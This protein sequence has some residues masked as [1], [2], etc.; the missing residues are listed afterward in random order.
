MKANRNER[1]LTIVEMA[2]TVTILS[3]LALVIGS[4]LDAG[5]GAY[6][7]TSPSAMAQLSHRSVEKVTERIAF[8]GL[9]TLAIGPEG[10]PDGSVL[11][12]R[13]CQ[14]SD[15]GTQVWGKPATIGWEP[16]PGDPEDGKDNDGDGFVDEGSVVLAINAGETDEHRVVLANGVAR[17]L[18][19]EKPNGLDDNGNGLVDER[20]LSFEIRDRAVHVRMTLVRRGRDGQVVTRTAR[21]TVALR[22]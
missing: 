2:I 13:A 21:D 6:R 17:H 8:A 15:A 11:T 16:E 3:G 5:L 18:E 10:A 19:G 14:G 4:V 22:N 1:G 12:F 20:G 7:S 9:A